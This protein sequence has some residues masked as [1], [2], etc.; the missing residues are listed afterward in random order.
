VILFGGCDEIQHVGSDEQASQLFKVTV[1]VVFHF[2]NT[3]RILTSFYLATV[4]RNDILSGANDGEGHGGHNVDIALGG[5]FVITLDGR[6]VALDIL[7]Q[8]N[9]SDLK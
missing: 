5:C 4:R 2:S 9:V 3:P 8:N 6:R 1:I 7:S